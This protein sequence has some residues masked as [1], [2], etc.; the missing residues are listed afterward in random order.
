MKLKDDRMKI[1]NEVFGQI[2]FIKVNAWEEF[3]Y[4]RINDKR[5]LELNIL[6]RYTYIALGNVF[7]AWAT[8]PL[9]LSSVFTW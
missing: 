7:L 5:D 8:F 9:I 3:F 6:T 4:K 2:K 1:T